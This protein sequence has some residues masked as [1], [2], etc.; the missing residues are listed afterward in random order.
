MNSPSE[1]SQSLKY[2]S[3]TVYSITN[4]LQWYMAKK[5]KVCEFVLIS[6]KTQILVDLPNGA[7]RLECRSMNSDF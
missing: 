3:W 2:Q 1:S 7:Y 4:R 5:I 6:F